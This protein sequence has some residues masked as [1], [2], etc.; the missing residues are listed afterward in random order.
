MSRI[1][2]FKNH[3]GFKAGFAV[4]VQSVDIAAPVYA[5]GFQVQD[6]PGRHSAR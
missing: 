4:L 1:K 5:P 6:L 3:G 2:L